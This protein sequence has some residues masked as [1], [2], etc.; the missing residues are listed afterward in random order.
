VSITLATNT[1][2]AFTLHNVLD[3]KV[4]DVLLLGRR[5]EDAVKREA[6]M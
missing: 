4:E 5:A 2:I 3:T 6:C 1:L